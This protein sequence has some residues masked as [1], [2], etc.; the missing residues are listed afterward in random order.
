MNLRTPPRA[1]LEAAVDRSSE[2]L[3]G[4]ETTYGE[5]T[6]AKEA[7]DDIGLFNPIDSTQEAFG[8]VREAWSAKPDLES[9]SDLADTAEQVS[10]YLEQVDVLIPVHYGNLL[11]VV[12]NFASDEIAATLGVG[13]TRTRAVLRRWTQRGLRP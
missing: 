8:H 13:P 1:E 2:T 12:D 9:I 4:I 6:A 3:R 11:N 5:V 7:I 10:P